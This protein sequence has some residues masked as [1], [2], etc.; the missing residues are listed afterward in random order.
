VTAKISDMAKAPKAASAPSAFVLAKVHH[1]Y[2]RGG[3]DQIHE[4]FRAD[5]QDWGHAAI[6][7]DAKAPKAAG[8]PFAYADNDLK[9]QHVVYRS[10]D[11]DVVELANSGK[12]WGFKNLS[13]EAK[14]PA[15]AA[16]VPTAF[17]VG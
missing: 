16:G 1:V 9:T 14:A 6:G 3:D 2:Y 10:A 17:V 11:G 12:G 4:L 15:K 5:G 8:D 13:A 7:A